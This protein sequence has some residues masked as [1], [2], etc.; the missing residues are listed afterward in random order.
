VQEFALLIEFAYL[1]DVNGINLENC[2]SMLNLADFFGFMGLLR[3]CVDFC[4]HQILTP[5]NCVAL[6]GFID[7]IE[8]GSEM[9]ELKEAS[10]KGIFNNFSQ[11][12]TSMLTPLPA[13]MIQRIMSDDFLNVKVRLMK[14][15]MHILNLNYFCRMNNMYGTHC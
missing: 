5:N 9:K 10:W 2:F 14:I 15:S 4:I 13:D 12:D 6:Y 3:Y 1:R 8:A 7:Q 11:I